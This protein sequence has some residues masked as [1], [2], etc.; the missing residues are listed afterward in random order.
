VLHLAHIGGHGMPEA[1]VRLATTMADQIAIVLSNLRLQEETQ[2]RSSRDL[3]TGLFTANFMRE[4]LGLE[5]SR[6]ARNKGP[7]GVIAVELDGFTALQESFGQDAVLALVR[8]FAGLLRSGIRK[9]DIA[10]RYDERRFLL[11]LPQAGREVTRRRAEHLRRSAQSLGVGPPGK[12][13]GSVSVSAGVSFYPEHGGGEA[14]LL[15]AAESALRRA[16]EAGGD[17][18]VVAGE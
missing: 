4:C 16:I 13:I 7:L 3:L 5:L 14:V 1:K 9:E 6:A 10:C 15:Q 2:N 8:Q 17:T 11:L 12:F 18:V